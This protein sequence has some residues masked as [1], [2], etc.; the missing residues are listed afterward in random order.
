MDYY[1]YVGK[2]LYV[3]LTSGE[4]ETQRL[5]ENVVKEFLGGWGINYRLE[6]DLLKPGTDP[7]SPDNPIIIGVG[8]LCGTLAPASGKCMAT[9]K[10]PICA[11][12]REECFVSKNKGHL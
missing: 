1:G 5:D 8:L 3:D 7:L 9:M 2:I 11:S 4:I 6:Y 10:L 12:K